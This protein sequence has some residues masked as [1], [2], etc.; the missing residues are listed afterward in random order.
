MQRYTA[1]EYHASSLTTRQTLTPPSSPHEASMPSPLPPSRIHQLTELTSLTPCASRTAATGSIVTVSDD[2]MSGLD[3]CQ[4]MILASPPADARSPK[5]PSSVAMPPCD[6]ESEKTERECADV[7]RISLNRLSGLFPL[8]S[9]KPS[10]IYPEIPGLP[11]SGCGTHVRCQI[12]IPPRS[13]PEARYRPHG[14]Q[15]R[16]QTVSSSSS[17]GT[18]RSSTALSSALGSSAARRDSD[19]LGS[20]SDE[21]GSFGW[22]FWKMHQSPS[23]SS[24]WRWIC[25]SY[26]ADARICR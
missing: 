7:C 26:D 21:A 5:P 13:P 1:T 22:S 6:H 23:G 18:L 19:G 12:L 25:E 11:V 8:P 16:L 24:N 20:V 15:P 10:E 2:A 14:L 9:A 4:T 3:S 17:G